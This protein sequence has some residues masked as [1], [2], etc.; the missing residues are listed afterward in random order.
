MKIKS[1]PPTFNFGP[2]DIFSKSARS[3]KKKQM[4]NMFTDTALASKW[5]G[6]YYSCVRISLAMDLDSYEAT[7]T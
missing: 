4:F 7:R 3:Y 2:S 6:K 5:N 1:L